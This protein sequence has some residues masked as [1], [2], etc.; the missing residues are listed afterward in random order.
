[1]QNILDTLMCYSGMNKWLQPYLSTDSFTFVVYVLRQVPHTKYYYKQL[2][3]ANNYR[4]HSLPH[5][6]HN[7]MTKHNICKRSVDGANDTNAQCEERI[8]Q[9]DKRSTIITLFYL[10]LYM[11]FTT[12]KT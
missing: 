6:T 5:Y 4:R 12:E 3:Y 10:S 7:Y 8:Y 11:L 2:F 1:M 9:E